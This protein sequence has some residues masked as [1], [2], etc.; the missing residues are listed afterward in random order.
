MSH[1]ENSVDNVGGGAGDGGHRLVGE[2]FGAK[3]G[4]DVDDMQ[5]WVTI[6]ASLC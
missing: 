2:S 1:L 5:P 6:S 3:A 4:I